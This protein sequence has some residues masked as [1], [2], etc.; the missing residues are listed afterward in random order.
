MR[1]VFMNLALNAAEAIGDGLGVISV[2]TGDMN[3]DAAYIGEALE[4]WTLEPGPCVFLEVRDTGCGM[5][6]DTKARIFD[7]FFTTK[8]LGRGLG[9]AAVAGIVRAHKG[10]I[11]VTTAPGAGSTFR[12]LLPKMASVAVAAAPTAPREEDL[13][14]AGTVLVVDDEQIVRGKA[15]RSWWPKTGL[16]PSRESGRTETGFNWCFST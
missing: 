9:L 15:T 1:Q 12:V 10:A 16:P 2:A 6:A 8:F 11:E 14:G 13:R 4:G 7:P 3:V 5:E